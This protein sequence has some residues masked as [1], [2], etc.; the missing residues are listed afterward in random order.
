M[1]HRSFALAEKGV[2]AST[3]FPK[4]T[5][6]LAPLHEVNQMEAPDGICTQRNLHQVHARE[7]GQWE[8]VHILGAQD[9]RRALSG[10]RH[11]PLWRGDVWVPRTVLACGVTDD[12]EEANIGWTYIKVDVT[13]GAE[14][15]N[16]NIL[17]LHNTKAIGAGDAI[18]FQCRGDL[19]RPSND[20][21]EL[22]NACPFVSKS[23]RARR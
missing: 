11:R 22:S 21:R 20:K 12:E 1:E 5:H 7:Q 4:D 6:V 14:T 9:R 13:V 3:D 16:V 18:I 17:V 19:G 8:H 15:T 10:W 2:R 23:N